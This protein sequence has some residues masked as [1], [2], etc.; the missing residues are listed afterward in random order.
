MTLVV[1]RLDESYSIPRITALADSRVSI[2]DPRIRGKRVPVTDYTVKLFAIPVRCFELNL[3]PVT[4]AFVN[5]YMQTQIGIGFS[6]SAMEGLSVIFHISQKLGNLATDSDQKPE[7]TGEGLVSLIVKIVETYFKSHSKYGNPYLSL[8]VFG[9]ENFRPWI[10]KIE[11]PAVGNVTSSTE[12]AIS[13]SLVSVGD[14]EDYTNRLIPVVDAVEKRKRDLST[15]VQRITRDIDMKNEKKKLLAD[16][17]IAKKKFAEEEIIKKM[18]D[19]YFGSIGG[20][21]QKLELSVHEGQVVAAFTQNAIP[22]PEISWP[23]VSTAGYLGPITINENMGK[24]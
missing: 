24:G 16:A 21:L 19:D 18:L 10:S 8:I 14:I 5:P 12:W 4:G 15:G 11:R 9:F 1:V 23:S 3:A 6:G 2:E 17:E 7:P 20:I 13:T 22:G